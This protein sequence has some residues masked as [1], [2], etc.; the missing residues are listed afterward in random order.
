MAHISYEH[1][2]EEDFDA[3]DGDAGLDPGE[4]YGG[5]N[6]DLPTPVQ[7]V[8]YLLATAKAQ[9]AALE[10]Y[11]RAVRVLIPQARSAYLLRVGDLLRGILRG[12]SEVNLRQRIEANAAAEMRTMAAVYGER[13]AAYEELQTLRS[14]AMTF[15][16]A[17]KVLEAPNEMLRAAARVTR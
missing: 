5:S 9:D 15:S 12:A 17:I 16:S 11:K 7:L 14:K 1:D 8:P 2:E 4:P 6:V 10:R 13:D 3:V